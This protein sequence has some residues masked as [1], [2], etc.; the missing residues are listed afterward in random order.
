MSKRRHSRFVRRLETEFSAAGQSYRAI[1]SDFSCSGLFIRTN[2]A[3]PPGTILDISVHLPDGE[4]SVLQGRVRRALKTT[5][6]SLKNGMGVELIEKD[7]FYNKFMLIF[8]GECEEPEPKLRP[9]EPQPE[10][11]KAVEPPPDSMIIACAACG[12]KNKVRVERL[13]QG[14]KCGKCGAPLPAD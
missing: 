5:V 7:A 10:P 1:S 4:T 2:H 12:V 8:T 14:P 9:I 3:F 13:P 6:V 11:A